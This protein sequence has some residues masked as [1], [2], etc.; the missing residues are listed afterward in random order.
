[1]GI[2]YSSY[3]AVLWPCLPIILPKEIIGTGF[4]LTTS[5]QNIGNF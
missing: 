1:M 5:I 2:F 3:A 4:G